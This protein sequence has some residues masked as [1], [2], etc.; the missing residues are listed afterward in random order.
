MKR[1]LNTLKEI[2]QAIEEVIPP[3]CELTK[4]ELE[5]PQVVLYLKNIRAF[6]EDSFLITKI[7][8]RIRRKI[9][10]RTDATALMPPTEALNLVKSLIPV[11]AGVT[12]IKFDVVFHEVVV[13]ALKPGLVIGKG[14]VVLKEIALQTGWSPKV[15]RAP[16]SPS[17]IEK[18]IRSFLIQSGEGRKKFLNNLGKKMLIPSSTCEWVKVTALGAYREVGRACTLVQTPKSNI[19]VDCGINP[20][21]SDMSRAY[22]YLNAAGLSLDQIDA[23]VLTHAHIDHSGFIPYLYAY[24]Y[25]GP[26]YCTPPT[27][28]LMIL[29]QQDGLHVTASEGRQLPY[30]D[31]DIKKQLS[32]IIV[33]DYGE[34]TDITPDLRFTFHNAGHILGSAVVHLHIGEGAHNLVITGDMKFGKTRLLD[35]AHVR[36]PRV[37]TLITESTYGG[38]QDFQPRLEDSEAKLIQ[39]VKE[40]VARKGKVLIPVFAVGRAQEIMLVLEDHLRNENI[41]VY[42]DGMSREASAIHTVYPEYLKANI[43]RRILQNNSPFEHPMFRNVIGKERRDIVESEEPCVVL[44]SS[45]M[46][47]GGTSV[48]FLKLMGGDPKNSLV[49]VGY[50]SATSL[51]RKL[52]SGIREVPMLNDSNKLDTLRINLQVDT[53]E[54]YSGHSDRNQLM[55]F[56][57]SIRPSPKRIITMHGDEHNCD[58]LA[59]DAGRVLR[60]E[61]RALMNLDSIR[62]K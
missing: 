19:I 20:D 32:N 41:P 13:E 8:S 4:V 43:Q 40:T 9:T 35:P 3:K 57:R 23:V 22:P 50:Q 54:G 45:G 21:T 44:A 26:V 51:G 62:L 18:S 61:S 17:E 27:R 28:D 6:Y 39:L 24:G 38:K 58:E 10:L 37:D 46:L 31:K 2:Q 36:F 34:V 16:T 5:G 56:I 29:L 59:R 30:T 25:D 60:V 49:F 1:V 48:E 14:G 42:I 53:I 11:D 33:R 47:M 12:D 7:A 55:A 52:Q 15:L